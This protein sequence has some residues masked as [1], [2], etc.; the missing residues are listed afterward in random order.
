MGSKSNPHRPGIEDDE[1]R[2]K[3]NVT[4]YIEPMTKV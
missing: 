2:G 1:L 4:K 3:H